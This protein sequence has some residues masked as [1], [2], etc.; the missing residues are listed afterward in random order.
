[1]LNRVWMAVDREYPSRPIVGVGV[2]VKRGD[3][4][5]LVRRRFDPGRGKWSIPGGLVELG[6][7]VRDAAL[8]EVYEETGLNVKL[9]RLL[10]VVDYIERSRDGRVRFHY[11]LVDFLAYVEG[12]EKVKPSDE[13]LEV[14]WV[15]ASEVR[16]YDITDSLRKLLDEVG[17]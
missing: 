10:S 3:R 14:R 16:R 12:S 11:V 17:I 9:D 13:F 7:T 5:L 4:V 2:L 1:M 15:K 8:R 6:E